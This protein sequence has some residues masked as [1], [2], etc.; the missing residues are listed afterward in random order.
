MSIQSAGLDLSNALE[1]VREVWEEVGLGWDDAVRRDFEANQ[2]DALEGQV[3]AVLQAI[4]RV[5]PVL[6]RAVRDCS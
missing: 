4:D 1:T 3:R 6:A 5:A 2:W